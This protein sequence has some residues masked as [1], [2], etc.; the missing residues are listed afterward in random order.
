VSPFQLN[1]ITEHVYW[2]PPDERTDRPVLGAIVGKSATQF[3]DAGNSPTHANL[4][5]EGL[6]QI[7]LPRSG[8][9]VLTHWHWDHVFGSPAFNLPIIAH[10]ETKRKIEEMAQLD[11]KDEALD[12]RVEEGTEIEFCRDM[13][14]A[15]WPDR[16][17]LRFKPPDISFE[18]QIEFDLGG[19]TCQVKHVGGDH[20]A[21][22]SVVYIPEDKV[23]F[24]SD[25]LYEDLHHGPPN[26]TTQNLFPLIDEILRYN[27]DHYFLGHDP[28]P[29]SKVGMIGYTKFL[30]SV[31]KEVQLRGD[32]RKFILQ[33]L[34][35]K[36]G[37][38]LDDD[39]LEILEA[40]IAGLR[41]QESMDNQRY[42]RPA[43]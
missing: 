20:A 29:L 4:L 36:M 6:A 27:A 28:E 33:K 34:E 21:D 23:L 10:Q 14:K 43:T 37:K 26:Y 31:G 41:Y 16:T 17:H 42:R 7:G 19:L 12:N 1:Q 13:I 18:T 22:S 24:L 11:W 9:L 3:V 25:C 15:E 39:Q 5:L 30:K 8:Y 32:D 40:F 2:L 35:E 38:L